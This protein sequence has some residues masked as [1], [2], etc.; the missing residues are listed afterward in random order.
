MIIDMARLFDTP[1]ITNDLSIDRLLAA[2]LPVL[3][4]VYNGN[5]PSDMVSTI[6]HLAK[7]N[8]GEILIARLDA[9]DNP[10]TRQRYQLSRLPGL[11]T[12]KNGQVIARVE[13]IKTT[14]LSIYTNQ[15]LG[16]PSPKSQTTSKPTR[17]ADQNGPRQAS[18]YPAAPVH[19]TDAS[20]DQEVIRSEIPVLVDFWAS[21][22]GPCRMMDPVLK[23]LARELSG[24]VKVA[25]LNVDENP[26]TAGRFGV[27][28]IP[29]MMVVRNGQITDKW[30]GAMPAPTLRSRLASWLM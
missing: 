2:G 8:A 6:E 5:L 1:L 27:Q 14:D 4:L 30:V 19:I 9:R 10:T 29:T 23:D 17:N 18:Q 22:C 3:L 26:Q 16:K 24:R 11:V 20:F 25:K 21:W 15:L 28:S 12:L 7:E 13:G